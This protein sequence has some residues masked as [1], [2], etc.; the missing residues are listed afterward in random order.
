VNIFFLKVEQNTIKFERVRITR[1]CITLKILK[2]WQT[3]VI[4]DFG[5]K[6]TVFNEEACPFSHSEPVPGKKHEISTVV[7]NL[8]IKVKCRDS[9]Y[10][11][12]DQHRKEQQ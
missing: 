11:I 1:L 6:G 3:W 10:Q 5:D 9:T 12:V 2:N 8:R 7:F 4:R